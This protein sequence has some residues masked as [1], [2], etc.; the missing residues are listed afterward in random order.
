MCQ[1]S[2]LTA[3]AWIDGRCQSFAL[4]SD[5]MGHDKYFTIVALETILGQILTQ[6]PEVFIT[7]RLDNISDWYFRFWAQN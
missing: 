7:P 5:Y 3:C 6:S 2:I 1:V 4:V